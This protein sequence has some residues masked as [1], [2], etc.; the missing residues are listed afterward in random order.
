MPSG[1]WNVGKKS[2]VASVPN[3]PLLVF[4]DPDAASLLALG[5]GGMNELPDPDPVFDDER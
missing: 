5:D 4:V 2:A 1:R 3:P